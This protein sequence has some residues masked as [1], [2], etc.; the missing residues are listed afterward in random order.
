MKSILIFTIVKCVLFAQAFD[1]MT[2]VTP[3]QGGGGEGTFYTHLMDNDLNEINTWIHPYGPAS[4]PYLN[5]DSTLIYP[6]RVPNPTMSVGGVGG[7]ISI[8]SWDGDLLWDY[9]VS[10]E[11]YQHHHDVEPLPN[12]N[13]LV[14]AWEKKT[15]SEAYAAGRQSIDNS[16]NEMWATAILE[17]EPL[18]NNEA[19][20]V[21]EW[22]IWDHLIQ[23]ADPS[24]DNYGVV[25][26]H[27]ELQDIN[28]GDAG[29]NQ[30]PGGANGDWKHIN[31]IDYN[32][33]LDQIVFFLKI[34]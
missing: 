14:I 27:P 22:H 9:E 3:T 6:Y 10:D 13:I 30:G 28:Y 4:M 1:G 24:A 32:E 19:N 7:G 25:E 23:D 29:S 15:A 16:L 8:Y 5:S 12:G 17:L 20:I 34:S 11:N 31:A 18:G 33:H 2:L 21:W 26:D